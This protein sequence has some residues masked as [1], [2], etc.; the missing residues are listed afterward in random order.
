MK[1]E[2]ESVK[3]FELGR[4]FLYVVGERG[5]GRFEILKQI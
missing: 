4:C 3:G 1:H 5:N 2:W